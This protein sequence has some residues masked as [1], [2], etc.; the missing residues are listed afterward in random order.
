[1][2][3]MTKS[4]LGGETEAHTI[5]VGD[6]KQQEDLEMYVQL[7]DYDEFRWN[8]MGI[9]T[10]WMPNHCEDLRRYPQAF[11]TNFNTPYV[12]GGNPEEV[13]SGAQNS[14]RQW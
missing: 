14:G 10:D 5:L 11:L 8:D 6:S 4:C 1:M 12:Y 9:D 3:S 7:P 2:G 13:I